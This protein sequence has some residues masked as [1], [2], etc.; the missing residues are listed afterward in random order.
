MY[1][2]VL[3]RSPNWSKAIA[4]SFTPTSLQAYLTVSHLPYRV[5]RWFC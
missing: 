2:A 3:E 4:Y 1:E 5:D